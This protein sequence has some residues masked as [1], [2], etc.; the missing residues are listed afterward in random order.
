M[1]TPGTLD[2]P[3]RSL[4]VSGSG[5]TSGVAVHEG[6]G[7]A[8]T[9]GAR[10]VRSPHASEGTYIGWLGNGPGNAATFTVH[11]PVAGRYVLTPH[12][13]NNDRRDNGHAYNTDIMSRIAD[14]TVGGGP[15]QRVT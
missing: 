1:T 12:Y 11:A 3:L 5:D 14:L 6:A 7:A 8:L 9:G 2:V 4:D 10:L 13:S 15:A